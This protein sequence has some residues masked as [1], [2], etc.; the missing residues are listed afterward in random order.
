MLFPHVIGSS[1]QSVMAF[2]LCKFELQAAIATCNL[3]KIGSVHTP[4][5]PIFDFSQSTLAV[6]VPGV[7]S[8]NL[9]VSI[10]TPAPLPHTDALSP[11]LPPRTAHCRADD[12]AAA[13]PARR[14]ARA[15]PGR[16]PRPAP[17]SLPTV[18]ENEEE[19]E[20]EEGDTEPGEARTDL[21]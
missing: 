19:Q 17:P 15:R 2:I 3:K 16:P 6:S 18:A 12:A 1:T 20:A 10:T 5:R 7:L 11:N 4:K 21:H 13:P 8:G 14:S 9:H